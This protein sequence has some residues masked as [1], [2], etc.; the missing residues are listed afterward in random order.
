MKLISWNVN[1]LRACMTHGFMDFFNTIDADIFS[2]QE[3]KMQSDQ[4]NY[5]FN[6]Y[7]TY[8]SYAM[9]KGYSGTAILTKI[10]PINVFYG[11]NSK[12]NDEGRIITLE[13]NDFYLIN[14]YS[15]NSKEGLIRLPYRMEFEDELR[16]YI[17]SLNKLKSV[18][19]CGDLNVAHME[20]DIK[21]PKANRLNAGFSDEERLKFSKLLEIGMI[22]SFR[23]INPFVVKYSWWS[24]RFNSRMN[25]AGWRIDYF[26]LS[27]EMKDKIRSAQIFDNITGSDHCPVELE[28]EMAIKYYK[29]EIQYE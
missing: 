28:I 1:G 20:I 8:M 25:N 15:P 21:N 14:S 18:I 5:N 16:N 19:L 22:D 13:F 27:K 2:L 4:W 17:D 3:I 11:I 23:E 7:Y 6:G 26:L 12:Y 24:Y 9:K 29:R 10:K